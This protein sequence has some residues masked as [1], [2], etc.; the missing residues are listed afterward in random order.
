LTVL[1]PAPA[2]LE[3]LKDRYRW[4]ILIKSKQLTRLHEM[5]EWLSSNYKTRGLARLIIDIDPE[6]ML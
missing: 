5:I 1:G 3:R 4:Q 6:N 2:P